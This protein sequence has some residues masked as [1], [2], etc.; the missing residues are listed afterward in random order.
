MR[1]TSRNRLHYAEDGKINPALLPISLRSSRIRQLGVAKSRKR[2]YQTITISHLY[3]HIV[4]KGNVHPVT[5]HEGQDEKWR[6]SC[7]ISL[8]LSL[9]GGG[10]APYPRE[11]DPV[12]TVQ[13]NTWA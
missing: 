11:R 6:Y 7:T 5:G 1:P 2:T 8:N 12:S 9:D 4:I 3:K 10:W 13:E